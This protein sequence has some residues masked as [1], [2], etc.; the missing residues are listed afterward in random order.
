V[1]GLLSL[2]GLWWSVD[3][4]RAETAFAC[5]SV[6]VRVYLVLE[7]LSLGFPAAIFATVKSSGWFKPAA[8]I[9]A[10]ERRLC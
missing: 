5:Q 7:I 3:T 8:R 4:A 9:G 6:S 10:V 2:A 1:I